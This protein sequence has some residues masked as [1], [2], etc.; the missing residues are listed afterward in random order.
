MPIAL[1]PRPAI[2]GDCS[3]WYP[4]A[5]HGLLIRVVK[6]LDGRWETLRSLH[7]DHWMIMVLSCRIRV[8]LLA[9]E[10]WFTMF[11]TLFSNDAEMTMVRPSSSHLCCG[12]LANSSNIRIMTYTSMSLLLSNTTN[13][14]GVVPA[15]SEPNPTSSQQAQASRSHLGVKHCWDWNTVLHV[16]LCGLGNVKTFDQN[17]YWKMECKVEKKASK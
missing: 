4:H 6:A 14:H 3:Q 10:P 5:M 8:V 1:R 13:F 2:A 12:L 15:P 16:W 9:L 7:A 11:V 17:K